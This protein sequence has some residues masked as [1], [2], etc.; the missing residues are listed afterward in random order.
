MENGLM[1]VVRT[2]SSISASNDSVFPSPRFFANR[3]RSA[4]R[5]MM[6]DARRQRLQFVA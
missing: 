6:R 3:S 1:A 2:P 4:H 5:P